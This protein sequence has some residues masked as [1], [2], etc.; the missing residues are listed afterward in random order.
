MDSSGRLHTPYIFVG[1][2]EI[3]AFNYG[4]G[5]SGGGSGS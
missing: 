1:D 3:V 4:E 2:D 5:G